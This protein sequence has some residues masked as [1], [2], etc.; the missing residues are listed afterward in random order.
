MPV[1]RFESLKGRYSNQL[2]NM[3]LFD[4]CVVNLNSTDTT[5]LTIWMGAVNQNSPVVLF[6]TLTAREI[7]DTTLNNN[8]N[9]RKISFRGLIP[10]SWQKR[11]LNT[12]LPAICEKHNHR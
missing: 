1:G 2:S 9:L 7:P 11:Q 3:Q 6:M 10:I 12:F 8:W 5:I 4:D